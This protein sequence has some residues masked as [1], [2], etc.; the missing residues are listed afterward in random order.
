VRKNAFAAGALP[1]TPLGKLTRTTSKF[2]FRSYTG[3]GDQIWIFFCGGGRSGEKIDKREG[4]ER[5]A[6][7]WCNL[8]EVCFLSLIAGDGLP[9]SPVYLC[10]NRCC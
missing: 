6:W 9:D 3:L 7:V 5:E 4:K 1:Q 10:S 8:G 2:E